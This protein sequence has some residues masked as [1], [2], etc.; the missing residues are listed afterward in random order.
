MAP[1]LAIIA[2]P[3]NAVADVIVDCAEAHVGGLVIISAG[4]A[5]LGEL[6][7]YEER[8]LVELARG[9]G[10]R[11][12]GPNCMGLANTDP[13]IKMNATFAPVDPMP[14][15]VAFMTQSGALGI[16]LIDESTR[17]GIGISS[18][19]SV[20]NKADISGNDLLRYWEG[21]NATAVIALYL[22]SF[23]NPR[24]FVQIASRVARRKPVVAVKSGRSPAGA[25]GATSHSAA[26]ATSDD[27][28]ELVLARAGVTRVDTLE[29]LFDTTQA[30]ASQPPPR[31]RRV[32]IVGNAGGPAI[33]A[34]DAAAAHGLLIPELCHETQARLASFLP[35]AAAIRNP[36]DIVASGSPV[37]FEQALN[38]VLDDPEIDAVLAIYVPPLPDRDRVMLDAIAAAAAS[39]PYKTMLATVLAGTMTVELD[40]RHVPTYRFPESAVRALAHMVTRSEWLAT[41]DATVPAPTTDL[42]QART[43]VSQFLSE[44]PSG[45]WLDIATA[46]A[47][48][49]AAGVP[50]TLT[51][52]VTGV[53]GAVA[54]ATR[55]GFPVALKAF[56]AAIVHKTDV[57]AVKLTLADERAV[58]DAAAAM[59]QALGDRLEGYVVQRMAPAGVE[60]LAGVAT[61]PTFGPLVLFGAGGTAAELLRDRV[62]RPAPLTSRDPGDMVRR[63]RI[64][65]LLDGYRGLP[66]IDH[67]DLET[68]LLRLGQLADG[69][70][71]VVEVDLNPVIATPDGVHIVDLRVR[72]EPSVAHPELSV[73][74]LR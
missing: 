10:M 60:F 33:L 47:L 44:V 71:E 41:A 40:G 13:A 43:I 52:V 19:V 59:R 50:M 20:G 69:V 62:V 67:S 18:F 23:G 58:A 27:V 36:V 17:R 63:L 64:S 25:R 15:N 57:G 16:S 24:K 37:A 38:T 7:R 34:A 72:V 39:H 66:P 48:A 14:G 32:A 45:G 49:E 22:E 4:F 35:P 46:L 9:H 2:V 26:L 12:V 3:A 68:L 11:V 21:D 8:A 28:S 65:P 54:A 5:E 30:F 74:R 51:E 53:D 29:E 73:R 70:P 6:R 55:L 31:G 61:D 42:T 56:G 1:D